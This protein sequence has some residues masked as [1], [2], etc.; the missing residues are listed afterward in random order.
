M[1]RNSQIEIPTTV[2][3]D[4]CRVK[5]T[6]INGLPS[7]VD[8]YSITSTDVANLDLES[9]IRSTAAD[10]AKVE[11]S[12]VDAKSNLKATEQVTDS[13]GLVRLST[14]YSYTQDGLLSSKTTQSSGGKYTESYTYSGG[15]LTT[16]R[17][18]SK[19][20][21]NIFDSVG[22][23]IRKD[24]FGKSVS[25]EFFPTGLIK[26][27]VDNLTGEY[28]QLDYNGQCQIISKSTKRGSET[29]K[30]TADGRV[31]EIERTGVDSSK[32]AFT[33]NDSEGYKTETKTISVVNSYDPY[34]PPKVQT[35][36]TQYDFNG[37][38]LMQTYNGVN[39]FDHKVGF[40]SK[41][42]KTIPE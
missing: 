22:N 42:I 30:Y 28:T 40:N 36:Q 3:L 29:Y 9:V 27:R 32:R 24:S 21:L 17:S 38:V 18:P 39:H 35:T 26:K 15:V 5:S 7:N 37:N 34:S 25:Y 12:F 2:T 23:Q 14:S 11:R 20:D 33:Y 41:A 1:I 8:E 13:G 10:G 16:V 6:A 31:L 4:S 19:S